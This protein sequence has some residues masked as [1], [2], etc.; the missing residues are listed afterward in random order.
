M[1]ECSE[2][3]VD[4]PVL[5]TLLHDEDFL[6]DVRVG[7]EAVH[8]ANENVHGLVNDKLPGNRLHF[9]GPR[10]RKKQRL[11]VCRHLLHDPL[12]LGFESHVEHA[13]G[14]VEDQVRRLVEG[15]H[16]LLEKVVEAT[17]GGNND[18]HAVANVAKLRA[19][20]G[21][22]IHAHVANARA[23]AKLVGLTLDLHRKLARGR[24]HKHSRPRTR[25]LAGVADVKQAGD[26]EGASLAAAGFS[27]ADHIAALVA[28][29]PCLGLNDG[30]VFVAGAVNFLHDVA[31]KLCVLKV[32]I[33][34]NDALALNCDLMLLAPF[35]RARGGLYVHDVDF[36][37]WCH[38]RVD[39]GTAARVATTTTTIRRAITTILQTNKRQR[40]ETKTTRYS[41]TKREKWPK[42]GETSLVH[43]R[44]WECNKEEEEMGQ[45]Q[46][47]KGKGG[48]KKEEEE[49]KERKK[50]P[51][52]TVCCCVLVKDATAQNS[53]APLQHRQQPATV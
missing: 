30:W 16:A 45:S 2:E 29:W 13:V 44:G 33:R 11:T 39:R 26:Q 37:R 31:R 1:A 12:D 49:K 51:P 53:A 41:N 3:V 52:T 5:V 24:Q 28:Q 8:V 14:L 23:A 22:A 50:K 40:E 9:L 20:G 19:L 27:N 35:D 15:D 38:G 7:L 4:G 17:R 10:G 48:K 32:E 42:P 36:A 6:L 43:H 25:V 18:L 21:T 34:V 47:G 46:S